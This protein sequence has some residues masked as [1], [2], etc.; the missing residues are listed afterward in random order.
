MQ[1]ELD[2]L[3]NT[4]MRSILERYGAVLNTADVVDALNMTEQDLR[5]IGIAE[6]P[7]VPRRGRRGTEFHALDV[8]RF[9]ASRALKL[10]PI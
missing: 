2:T 3:I 10:S 7:R 1:P 6:L 4:F 9:Q 8:A 5:L